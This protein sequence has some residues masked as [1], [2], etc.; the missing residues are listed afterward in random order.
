MIYR[1]RLKSVSKSVD[2]DC[3]YSYRNLKKGNHKRNLKKEQMQEERYT[4]IERENRMLLEKMS[5]I[6]QHNSID[7]HNKSRQFCKSLNYPHRVKR[8][9]TINKRNK[10]LLTRIK[11]TKP[12]YD[13]TKWEKER[14]V[15]EH[16]LE[17]MGE[18]PYIMNKLGPDGKVRPA[19]R[20][21]LR[22]RHQRMIRSARGTRRP[23]TSASTMSLSTAGR[24]STGTPGRRGMRGST[25]GSSRGS[26]RNTGSR[27][28]ARSIGINSSGRPGTSESMMYRPNTA[29]SRLQTPEGRRHGLLAPMEDGLTGTEPPADL[30]GSPGALQSALI[31][32]P[33][34]E[35]VLLEEEITM[36]VTDE[37]VDVRVT[38]I[39]VGMRHPNGAD[40]C[41][42]LI[43]RGLIPGDEVTIEYV[44]SIDEVKQL[45]QNN[46]WANATIDLLEPVDEADLDEG[47]GQQEIVYKRVSDVAQ[48]LTEGFNAAV[49]LARHIAKSI[50]LLRDEE[51]TYY[52][53]A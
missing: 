19:T 26:L 46:A 43:I 20:E 48:T 25:R 31:P 53:S 30:L 34:H 37:H 5:W 1:R 21:K 23:G 10:E 4:L 6:M 15:M 35:V 44:C 2:N 18:Y 29:D 47:E 12:Y 51:G 17:H 27:M 36:S 40:G 39:E 42:G 11:K 50:K 7:M 49:T 24:R 22:R 33:S 9:Q 13:T 3:P 32:T 28:S 52:F 38:V 16:H 8:L 41:T 45:C 14:E